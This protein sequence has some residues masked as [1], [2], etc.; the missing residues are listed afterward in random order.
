VGT[1]GVVE[2]QRVGDRV[3]HAVGGAARVAALEALVV[4]GA[5]AGP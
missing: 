5:H 2:P 1:L 3:E 4:L